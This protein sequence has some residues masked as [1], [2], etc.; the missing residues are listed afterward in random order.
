ML[1]LITGVTDFFA[2]Y[3]SWLN[4]YVW[5][6]ILTG[7]EV[8]DATYF[9]NAQSLSLT[10]FGILGGILSS[11]TCRYKWQMFS[12]AIVRTI[13]IGLMIR[14]RH[15]GATTAQLV[16]PQIIQGAGGGIMGIQLQVAAQV[17]VP[18]ADVA[19]VTAF[20]LLMT[21]IGGAIGSAVAGA[22]QRTVIPDELAKQAPYLSAEQVAEVAAAP[23][24]YLTQP[25]WALGTPNRSALIAAWA[26]YWNIMLIIAIC[27]S[28]VPIICS[29]LFTDRKL[30]NKQTLVDED[31]K[32]LPGDQNSS[33][34]DTKG[35]DDLLVAHPATDADTSPDDD[36]EHPIDFASPQSED[37]AHNANTKW[38]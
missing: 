4:A 11:L 3:T 37:A 33:S 35:A 24:T 8:E 31:G 36:K 16:I 21:E 1:P 9:S 38:A 18:H 7:W 23:S 25:D 12:G 10:V 32:S 19:M 20:V 13:G 28:A 17:S 14:Y 29:A 5:V 15:E 22:V 27:V 6:T 34:D 30:N 2:F 26:K